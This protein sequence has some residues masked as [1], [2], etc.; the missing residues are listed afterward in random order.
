[1]GW[2]LATLLALHVSLALLF[3]LAFK[4]GN[5]AKTRQKGA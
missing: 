4:N 2:L 1:M 5:P 3:Y